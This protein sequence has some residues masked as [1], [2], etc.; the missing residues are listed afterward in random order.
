MKILSLYGVP[1]EGFFSLSNHSLIMPHPLETMPRDEVFF[2]LRDTEILIANRKVTGEMISS[3]P[4]L[5]LICAYGAGFDNIDMKAATEHRISVCNIPD[6]VT[7]STAEL[8]FSLLL[9]LSRR[10]TE[11][12][13]RLHGEEG[14]RLFRMG[15]N[16]GTSLSGLTLGIIGMGRIGKRMAE[17]GRCFGMKI[18]YTGPHFKTECDVLGDQYLPLEELLKISDVI[19][20][21]CP[22]N[23]ATFHLLNK[24]RIAMMKPSAMLINTA[25]GAIADETALLEALRGHRIAGAGLDVYDGEPQ[26]N[27]EWLKL[28]NV[29]TTPHIGSNTGKTRYEM[30][31]AISQA[32]ITFS[33]GERPANLINPEVYTPY[34]AKRFSE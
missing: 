17:M 33:K 24:E 18:A 13:I 1:K 23:S 20:L 30:A 6:A 16:M 3:A 15:A 34:T 26:L 9:S 5:R 31:Q 11:M 21:H 19:S 10:V 2:H 25:R 29:I 7:N 8:A 27:P 28:D 12:H 22:L 4:M 32:I 14:N